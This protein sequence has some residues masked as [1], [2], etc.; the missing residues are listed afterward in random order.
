MAP[1]R[2]GPAN[3][4][5]EVRSRLS[6]VGKLRPMTGVRRQSIERCGLEDY[7]GEAGESR[8]SR[9]QGEQFRWTDASAGAD[10]EQEEGGRKEGERQRRERRRPRQAR[11]P[12]GL[13]ARTSLILRIRRSLASAY[14]ARVPAPIVR[15]ARAAS[16]DSASRAN[17]FFSSLARRP[18]TAN[19]QK[20]QRRVWHHG[21]QARDGS[22][23]PRRPAHPSDEPDQPNCRATMTQPHADVTFCAYEHCWAPEVVNRFQFPAKSFGNLFADF[24]QIHHPPGPVG[25]TILNVSLSLCSSG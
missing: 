4:P 18:G 24:E 11:T 5:I 12:A 20:C 2:A 1:A 6:A 14:S 17:P 8:E 3:R 19:Q 25:H 13:R 7:S 10:A 15:T 9:A 21:W 23:K 16:I 22:C